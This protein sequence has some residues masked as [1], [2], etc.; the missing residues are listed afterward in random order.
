MWCRLQI[1]LLLVL[2]SVFVDDN[3]KVLIKL[4]L[5][6]FIY[7]LNPCARRRRSV[8]KK[9]R[10]LEKW[11]RT[12][13]NNTPTSL[14]ES[15]R[16]WAELASYTYPSYIRCDALRLKYYIKLFKQNTLFSIADE[17]TGRNYMEHRILSLEARRD[18]TTEHSKSNLISIFLFFF[19]DPNI[20][21]Y[22]WSVTLLFGFWTNGFDK[23]QR[24]EKIFAKVLPS[25]KNDPKVLRSSSSTK[26]YRN[27][28][29]TSYIE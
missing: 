1:L 24:S 11:C 6:E 19:S 29:T 13:S 4:F 22:C 8:F 5:F 21:L 23:I 15:L 14:N 18:A 20:F 12:H 28:T 26:A 10:P 27:Y 25:P 2:R 9:I 7:I 17:Y 16:I 3:N